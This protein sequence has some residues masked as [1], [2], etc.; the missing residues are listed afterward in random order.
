MFFSNLE[1]DE[2]T[3]NIIALPDL[4]WPVTATKSR[5][6]FEMAGERVK[7]LVYKF[8]SIKHVYI[9]YFNLF[10]PNN[11]FIIN[12]VNNITFFKITR[13]VTYHDNTSFMF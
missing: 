9:N 8:F 12:F 10:D 3:C 7:D 13:L 2:I 5:G 4:V 6:N 1:K 11:F